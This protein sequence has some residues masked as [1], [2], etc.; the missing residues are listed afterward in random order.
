MNKIDSVTTD[1]FKSASMSTNI[2]AADKPAF[3]QM[4]QGQVDQ[5]IST[6]NEVKIEEAK[7]VEDVTFEIKGQEEMPVVMDNHFEGTATR[8]EGESLVQ[9]SVKSTYG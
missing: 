5:A 8:K 4:K 6:F 3:Q 9:N 7:P 1:A 2:S